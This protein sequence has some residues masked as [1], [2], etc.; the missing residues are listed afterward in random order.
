[1]I[2]IQNSL[3]QIQF[4]HLLY[5]MHIVTKLNVKLKT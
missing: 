2:K 3:Y 1:M 5:I 4:L